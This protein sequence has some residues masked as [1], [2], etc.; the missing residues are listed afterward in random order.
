M[1]RDELL[2]EAEGYS[3]SEV[4]R[5]LRDLSLQGLVKVLWRT[6]F[7]FLA[8]A[9]DSGGEHDTAAVTVPV[10]LPG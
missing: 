8:V 6:P 7:R 5:A 10:G 9:T 4:E 1:S 3:F 2:K